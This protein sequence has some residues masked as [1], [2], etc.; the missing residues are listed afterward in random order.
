MVILLLRIIKVNL[1]VVVKV[2]TTEKIVDISRVC[3]LDKEWE[4]TTDKA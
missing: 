3:N 2:T 4:L 1:V